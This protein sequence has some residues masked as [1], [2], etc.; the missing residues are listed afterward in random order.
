VIDCEP[1]P[2]R[3][4]TPEEIAFIESLSE[5]DPVESLPEGLPEITIDDFSN[6]FIKAISSTGIVQIGF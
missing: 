6:P 5:P 1:P 4:P 2:P 3:P